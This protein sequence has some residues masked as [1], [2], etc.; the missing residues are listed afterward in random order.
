MKDNKHV[1]DYLSRTLEIVNKMIAHGKRL[2]STTIVGKVLHSMIPKFNYVVC[3]IK[4]SND[5]TILTIDEL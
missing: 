1:N 3:S 4:E 5:V 2:E